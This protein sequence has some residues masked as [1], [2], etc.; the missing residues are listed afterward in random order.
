[1]YDHTIIIITIILFLI[2]HIRLCKKTNL[3]ILKLGNFKIP[4]LKLKSK[5]LSL[6]DFPKK[7][8]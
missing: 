7:G 8:T 2:L 4:T 5:S 1:M 6:Y 3:K